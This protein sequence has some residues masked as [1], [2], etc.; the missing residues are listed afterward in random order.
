MTQFDGTTAHLQEGW[1]EVKVAACFSWDRA[2]PEQ[3]PEAISYVADWRAAEE[4]KELV[5]Q[6]ALG[7]GA[8][9]ARA[10]RR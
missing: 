10:P 4:F 6:E 7:R 1:K 9:T 5:D 8:P 2:A 3:G